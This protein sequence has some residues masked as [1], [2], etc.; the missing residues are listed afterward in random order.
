MGLPL[1]PTK[2]R[3][4]PAREL[5]T[6]TWRAAGWTCCVPSAVDWTPGHAPRPR[7]TPPLLGNSS[8]APVE[9][10][11]ATRR[12]RAKVLTPTGTAPTGAAPRP[13]GL[14]SL[15][16][17]QTR[18]PS[19]RKRQGALLGHPWERSAG[20]G[21]QGG[22]DPGIGWW[23]AQRADRR[24]RVPAHDVPGTEVPMHG[25]LARVRRPQ[26]RRS[27][28]RRFRRA[29]SSRRT[30]TARRCNGRAEPAARRPACRKCRS[31]RA[32][33]RGR[34]QPSKPSAQSNTA[35]AVCRRA[36]A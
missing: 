20:R 33:G 19:G 10:R 25:P 27:A 6:S 1:L 7:R 36:S 28:R 17:G 23:E 29:H 35:L 32:V 11:R 14:V 3:S 9:R 13:V 24:R 34:S 22:A 2:E 30:T 18:R 31:R 16:S 21:R 12:A 8:R 26:R 15:R 5:T 4:S